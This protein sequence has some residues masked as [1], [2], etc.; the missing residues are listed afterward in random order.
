MTFYEVLAQVIELLQRQGRVSY[1]A[2][3]R[4]FELDDAY[5]DDLKTELIQ[6]QRLALDEDGMVLVWTGPTATPP[7][8]TTEQ[9]KR[10][11]PAGRPLPQEQALPPAAAPPAPEAERR[12]LTVMFCDLVGSTPSPSNWTLRT[13]ARSCV[14]TRPPVPR[15]CSALRAILPSI[16]AMACS[17][18]LA[19]P[20]RTK[21]TPSGPYGPDWACWPPWGR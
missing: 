11:V 19:I 21:T 9:A 6:A 20:R 3:K 1:R 12:Q 16:S 18:T 13:C 2:L 4:Q 15:S 17:C 8:S 7:T 5:I 14:P 10:S